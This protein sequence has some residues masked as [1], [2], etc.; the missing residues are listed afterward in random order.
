MSKKILII[1]ILTIVLLFAVVVLFDYAIYS[2]N[3]HKIR[4]EYRILQPLAEDAIRYDYE[5]ESYPSPSVLE[6]IPSKEFYKSYDILKKRAA[7]SFFK[8]QIQHELDTALYEFARKLRYNFCA[9]TEELYT[10]LYVLNRMIKEPNFFNE[11]T[12]TIDIALAG[13]VSL[14]VMDSMME[15][16]WYDVYAGI[17][18]NDTLEHLDQLGFVYK[19]DLMYRVLHCKLWSN[20]IPFYTKETGDENF[21]CLCRGY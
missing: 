17:H 10:A 6:G 8:Q 14:C 19:D 1:S 9:E 18:A 2:F 13:K 16:Y 4:R 21:M 11:L 7:Y 15:E 12:S 5:R 3:I 20:F